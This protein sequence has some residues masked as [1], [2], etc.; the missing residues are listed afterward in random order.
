MVGSTSR[1]QPAHPPAAVD[2]GAELDRIFT[3][4]DASLRRRWRR[5][6]G[7]PMPKGLGRSLALRILAYYQQ[8]QHFGDLDRAS[9]QALA[10]SLGAPRRP[11]P[12]GPDNSDLEPV[13]EAA[14]ARIGTGV[15]LRPG[16]LLV[17]AHEGLSHRVMVL[18]EGFAWNG[19]TYESLSKVA[20]AITGTRWNGPRFFGLRDRAQKERGR[21]LPEA[22]ASRARSSRGLRFDALAP[23]ASSRSH[24]RFP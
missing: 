17:R 6:I 2:L 7:R 11:T 23:S 22:S 24:P 1:G 3:L 4:D 19:K 20:F 8:V 15:I 10:D 9:L 21:E 18:E 5:L 12:A 16:T 13:S 14:K